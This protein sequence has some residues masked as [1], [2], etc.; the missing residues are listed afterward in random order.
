MCPDF[1]CYF[2]RNNYL[3]AWHDLLVNQTIKKIKLLH[4]QML[5]KCFLVFL[6]GPKINQRPS[7]KN[8]Y[9][10]LDSLL[11]IRFAG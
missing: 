6:I 5:F 8:Y 2:S 10:L 9:M 4:L 7:V 3:S 1:V 11:K